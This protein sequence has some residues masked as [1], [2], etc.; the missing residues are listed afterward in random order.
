MKISVRQADLK[1]VEVIA[2]LVRELATAEGESNP[3]TPAY[4]GIVLECPGC[5]V[6]LAEKDGKVTGLLSYSIR[7][8][9]YHAANCCTVEELIV[10]EGQRREG[11][12]SAL[13]KALFGLP[14]VNKCAEVSVSTLLK[15]SSAIQFYHKHGFTDEALLL[16]KHW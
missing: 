12:G 9:L 10:R 7:P 14:E 3:L 16:E 8:N 5:H 1:D 4:T 15:N 13:M 6:L 11:I 2:K